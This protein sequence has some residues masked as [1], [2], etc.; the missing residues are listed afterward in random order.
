MA[1]LPIPRAHFDAADTSAITQCVLTE[2]ES[3][4]LGRWARMRE[5]FHPDSIV[6]ISWFQGSGP[7]FVERSI[8]W[9]GARCAPRTGSAPWPCV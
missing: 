6:R 2:R 1:D 8:A 4:D 5:C 7:D 9:P 3:R